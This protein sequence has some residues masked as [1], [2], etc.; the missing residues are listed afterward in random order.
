MASFIFWAL[1]VL[2]AAAPL[3]LGANRPWAWSLIAVALGALMVAWAIGAA[4]DPA[5]AP[6]GWRRHW[7]VS[8]PFLLLG[9]WFLLQTMSVPRALVDPLWSEAAIALGRPLA[10]T[11]SLDPVASR[12]GAM[13]FLSYGGVFW[14]A[15]QLGH[16]AK[17]ARLFYWVIAAAGAAYAVYGLVIELGGYNMLLWFTKWA[18]RDSLT[19]TFV[20]RNSYAAYAGLGLL[21]SLA[22]LLQVVRKNGTFQVISR[23]GF[24]Y[25]AESVTPAF[26]FLCTAGV[27][28]A[29]A[30]V[31]S[32]SRGG[33][34][35]TCLG[36]GVLIVAL[37]AAGAI[38]L[39]S[40]AVVSLVLLAGALFVIAYSGERLLGRF[41][42]VDQ[43][44]GAA[45]G[46]A[47]VHDLSWRAILDG[48]LAGR[49]LDTFGHVFQ[50][51]RDA[52]VP[53]NTPMHD[54]AHSLYL[55]M[56]V[57]GGPIALLVL[58]AMFAAIVAVLVRGAIRRHRRVIYPCVALASIALLGG[59]ATID[60][61]V[62]IPAIAVTFAALLG[63]GYAQS[64]NTRTADM[65]N[66][67]RK[68]PAMGED[69]E[70]QATPPPPRASVPAKIG[71]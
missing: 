7:F 40:A 14:L 63:V 42:L 56:A 28:L 25:F 59:H 37:A 8:A 66:A 26:F 70:P 9:A 17:R 69:D 53:W 31:L 45:G 67:A 62:Q 32:L 15:M 18:Y 38:R 13:R 43:P 44:G 21:V 34:A 39:T 68:R 71:A 20:N 49:G 23:T 22:L 12:E 60:F 33:L 36:V 50:M 64:F 35:F 54:K 41:M 57:E 48:P 16:D 10:G 47:A 46:R 30:L 55:E 27:V 11:I 6:I 58:L 1:M 5:L 19:S 2:V 51:Y 65:R 52:S 3:P 61:S 24:I 4:R 29:T